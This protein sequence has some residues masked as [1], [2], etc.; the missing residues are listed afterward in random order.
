MSLLILTFPYFRDLKD[1]F[2]PLEL[3]FINIIKNKEEKVLLKIYA[4]ATI[5]LLK[6]S[7]RLERFL[8][9]SELLAKNE[10]IFMQN[11]YFPLGQRV[12]FLKWQFLS[13]ENR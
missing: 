8:K 12:I 10:F 3:F 9:L 7:I 5:F 4:F 1:L 2:T 6:K 11:I 13:S